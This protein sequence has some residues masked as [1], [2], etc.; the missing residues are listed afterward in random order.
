MARINRTNKRWCGTHQMY[1]PEWIDAKRTQM[2][3]CYLCDD[4][5]TRAD[6]AADRRVEVKTDEGEAHG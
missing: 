6:A 4:E 2:G 3:T 1:Y 5:K